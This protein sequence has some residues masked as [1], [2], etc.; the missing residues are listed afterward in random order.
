MP[1]SIR[2]GIETALGCHTF[3]AADI[4][5]YLTKGGNLEIAQRMAGHSNAETTAS[6][7]A[8]MT[9]SASAKSSP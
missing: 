5:N 7:I 6:I 3:R 2:F 4:T 9:T 1:V 8:V